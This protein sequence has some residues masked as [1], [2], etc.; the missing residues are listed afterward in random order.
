M[1]LLL[2]RK[3]ISDLVSSSFF[4][5]Q[6]GLQIFDVNLLSSPH[7]LSE[8]IVILEDAL[9]VHSILFSPGPTVQGTWI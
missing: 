5:V 9:K 2:S 6:P 8:G 4:Q 3:F 7:L 1:E